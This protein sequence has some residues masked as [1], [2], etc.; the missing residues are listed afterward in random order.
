MSVGGR[1]L[2]EV[3]A[4][5][6]YRNKEWLEQKYITEKLSCQ[7][8]AAVIREETGQWCCATHVQ[9]WLHKHKIPVRSLSEASKV[10]YEN[11]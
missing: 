8:I 3:Y 10:R 2:R 6:P 11:G 9:K 4:K 1:A 7:K 5:R